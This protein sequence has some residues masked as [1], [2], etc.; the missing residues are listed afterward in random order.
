[1]APADAAQPHGRAGLS[2]SRGGRGAGRPGGSGRDSTRGRWGT[3]RVRGPGS[4]LT[5]DNAGKRWCMIVWQWPFESF[6]R[7]V[8]RQGWF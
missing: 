6:P 8:I 1:M 5:V 2:H 3:G 7:L 4:Q